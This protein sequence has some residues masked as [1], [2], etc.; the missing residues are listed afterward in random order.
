MRRLE[1]SLQTDVPEQLRSKTVRR[2]PVAE[3]NL[4][5]RKGTG[6]ARQGCSRAPQY[7][8]GGVAFGPQPKT[9]NL[10]MNKKARKLLCVQLCP[11]CSKN[12]RI[13]VLDKLEFDTI[14]TKDFV[15][16]L[17]RFDLEQIIDRY[18]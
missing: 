18:R 17:K 14:S 15:D 2:F 6:N 13:T 4:S 9:Y 12:D 7:P 5:N 11:C 8:G 1:F 3:K 16:F 10:S